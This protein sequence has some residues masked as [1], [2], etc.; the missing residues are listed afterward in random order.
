M[1]IE[2]F[3]SRTPCYGECPVYDVVVNNK[4]DVQWQG[5][6][7]VY[8]VGEAEWKVS[9]NK[10][11]DIERL[12]EAFDYRSFTYPEPDMFA[13][14]L[15]SCITKVVFDDGFVKEVNHD[16]GDD[17]S[18]YNNGKDSLHNLEKFE[19]KLEQILGL[20]KVIKNG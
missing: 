1:F 6:E 14:D 10:I 5:H 15:P 4:G 19:N 12:L 20:Q 7:F 16:L 18:F 11:N 8:H 9:K 17:Q 2:L 3:I 13:T